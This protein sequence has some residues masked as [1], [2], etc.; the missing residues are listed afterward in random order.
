MPFDSHDVMDIEVPCEEAI[1]LFA[2]HYPL[3]AG[4]LR[5]GRQ[6]FIFLFKSMEDDFMYAGSGPS[7]K[8]SHF[9]KRGPDGCITIIRPSPSDRLSVMVL[10]YDLDAYKHCEYYAKMIESDEVK[11]D[12][13][14]PYSW[15][16][17][18]YLPAYYYQLCRYDELDGSIG[19]L[20][21]VD[22]EHTWGGVN[23][24]DMTVFDYDEGIESSEEESLH[25]E[26]EDWQ[27]AE[28]ELAGSEDILYHE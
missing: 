11:M 19:D 10:R 15:E 6:S 7:P 23:D 25:S 14:G 20:P 16:F 24:E 26:D 8:E 9:F 22:E 3:T 28:N 2:N 5:N 4:R 12:P 27:T 18:R 1:E 13:T 17:S 21:V